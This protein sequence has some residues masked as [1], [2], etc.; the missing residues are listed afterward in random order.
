MVYQQATTDGYRY[1][2]CVSSYQGSEP[3]SKRY[4]PERHKDSRPFYTVQVIAEREEGRDGR[5]EGRGERE[6]ERERERA[7]LGVTPASLV[8][9][10]P[11]VKAVASTVASTE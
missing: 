4:C 9:A 5:R 8:K 1:E 10:V 6:R 3:C 7:T 11:A 2:I